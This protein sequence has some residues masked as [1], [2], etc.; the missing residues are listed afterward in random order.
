MGIKKYILKAIFCFVVL[1]NL[2]YSQETIQ[3]RKK[4]LKLADEA[5]EKAD[6]LTAYNL[7]SEIIKFDSTDY[8]LFY[9][10]GI[11]LF[12]IN[13]TDTNCLRFFNKSKNKIPDS[14]FFIGRIYHLNGSS[15][16]ALVEFHYY[17]LVNREENISNAEVDKEIKACETALRN[18]IEKESYIVRNIG[19]HINTNYS[20][21]VPLFWN[22][23]GSLVFT[24]RR[25]DS[26]GGLKDPYG[27][28]Y[29]DIYISKKTITGWSLPESLSDN[30]NTSF[31]DACVAFSPSG[32]DLIIYRTDEKKTGGDLFI[33]HYDGTKW[34]TPEKLGSEINSEYL[35]ASACFSSSG[36]E[37]IFSSNRPGGF[38]GKDLYITRKF[39]N[40]KYSLP[41]NLGALIN[42]P[43]DEDAPFIDKN[44]NSLYFSSK[45]HN[46]M[47][48]YDIFRSEFNAEL[49]RWSEPQNLGVPINSTNDD[50]YFTKLEDNGKALFSSRR[51]GGFG[52]ADIYEVNLDESSELIIYCKLNVNKT[53]NN[54]DLKDVQLSLYDIE[55]G[56]MEGIFKPNKNY[57]AFVLLATK[58]KPYKLIIEG[59][60]IDPIIK[61][62]SFTDAN[63]EISIDVYKKAK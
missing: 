29:E 12:S 57:M 21:Y 8:S 59:N 43:E 19:N 38:G 4:N 63:K 10:S 50:I 49:D 27:K 1:T 5:F 39:M 30:V 7:Y 6:F 40:G 47:G 45:G 53:D 48:E 28:F 2:S 36:N 22:V 58:D 35:E 42:T 11:C 33:S 26:K 56:K 34:S 18:D 60:N 41:Y 55:T 14:H 51:E 3:L 31:H 61:K 17:K 52:D 23:N 20:E 37:I 15:K 46:S 62:I 16:K 24:S 13:K 54:D 9:K 44:D 25:S 32:N